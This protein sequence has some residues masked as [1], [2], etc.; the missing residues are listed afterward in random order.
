MTMTTVM[1]T[2][3]VSHGGD[4]SCCSDRYH[5]C[6]KVMSMTSLVPFHL[7]LTLPF[8]SFC[9]SF[10]FCFFL[11][12][13]RIYPEPYMVLVAEY[14]KMVVVIVDLIGLR[15]V[16]FVMTTSQMMMTLCSYYLWRRM[17]IERISMAFYCKSLWVMML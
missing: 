11:A 14:E 1:T 16:W 7:V 9:F 10:S 12:L 6:V 8:P 15:P 4:D 13:M 2:M 5:Y 17:K 3:V